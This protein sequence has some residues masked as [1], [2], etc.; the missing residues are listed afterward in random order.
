[1]RVMSE[2]PTFTVVRGTPTAEELAAVI[3]VLVSVANTPAAPAAAPAVSAWW[4]SGLPVRPK[5]WRASG[6]PA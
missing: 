3:G 4:A 2:A 1:M 5:N 6:L